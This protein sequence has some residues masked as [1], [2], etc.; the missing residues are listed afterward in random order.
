MNIRNIISIVIIISF[1]LLY[2]FSI[3]HAQDPTNY[4]KI[5][6]GEIIQN[7]NSHYMEL[8]IAKLSDE[9]NDCVIIKTQTA[10]HIYEFNNPDWV[11]VDTIDINMEKFVTFA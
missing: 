6:E 9:N 5:Y 4:N 11:F 1:A 10:L 2:T 8:K 7:L 3:S